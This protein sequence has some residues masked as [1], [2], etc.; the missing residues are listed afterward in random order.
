M[1]P[2]RL[3]GWIHGRASRADH[4]GGGPKPGTSGLPTNLRLPETAVC[5]QSRASNFVDEIASSAILRVIIDERL[6]FN[7]RSHF[8]NVFRAIH[9]SLY[10]LQ[11][12]HELDL[13]FTS[14]GA[15]QMTTAMNERYRKNL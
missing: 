7:D 14:Y 9:S 12:A 3:A 11:A 5:S 8:I 2:R 10:V 6:R 13:L 15:V 1:R 4:I